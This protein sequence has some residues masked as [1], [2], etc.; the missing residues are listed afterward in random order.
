MYAIHLRH[1]ND[2]NGGGGREVGNFCLPFSAV[3]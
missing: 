1:V 2:E 3:H